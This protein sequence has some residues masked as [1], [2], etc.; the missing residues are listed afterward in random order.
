MWVCYD[1]VETEI[2]SS[3]S[4]R[5]LWEKRK[6]Q[7]RRSKILNG[8]A[9]NALRM[10][11][12]A[13]F[14][15]KGPVRFVVDEKLPF[16]GYTMD[17]EQE[18]S[19]V[20]AGKA[21]SSGMIE[22]LLVHELSHIY[23]TET[24]HPSHNHTLLNGVAAQ[25][26]AKSKIHARYQVKI[27]QE[28]VNHVQDLYADDIS[29]QVF[30]KNQTR[31]GSLD[32]IGEF[33]LSWTRTEPAQSRN[34]KMKVWLDLSVMLNNAFVISNLERHQIRHFEQ[35]AIRANQVFLSKIDSNLS[36]SSAHFRTFMTNLKEEISEH[37]FKQQLLKYMNSFIQLAVS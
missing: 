17:Q 14:R 4:K 12:N 26:A 6:E 5:L 18:H 2:R 19:I 22:G 9:D 24:N 36:E 27:L 23:R 34:R 16:M 37:E 3:L 7:M 31:L 20:V 32:Q 13:G 10:M 11:N 15:I 1:S 35:E 30:A 33:F 25:I 29:F 21:L 28:I 8:K